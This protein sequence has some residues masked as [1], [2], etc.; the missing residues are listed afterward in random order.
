MSAMDEAL[1]K[2]DALHEAE[3]RDRNRQMTVSADFTR[4]NGDE[5]TVTLT[6]IAPFE[7]IPSVG[8]LTGVP[9]WRVAGQ[10]SRASGRTA[11]Y[12]HNGPTSIRGPVWGG[13][14]LLNETEARRLAAALNAKIK[15]VA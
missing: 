3:S 11:A 6:G 13:L 1:A 8:A 2:I 4:D 5:L 7:A 12:R 15:K 9:G 10:R 14:P